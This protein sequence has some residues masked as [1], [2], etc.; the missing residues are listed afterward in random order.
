M[1][2]EDE[3]RDAIL[4]VLANKQDLPG[5]LTAQEV[6]DKLGLTAI[7]QRTWSQYDCDA[8]FCYYS[9]TLKWRFICDAKGLYLPKCVK[10]TQ[11]CNKVSVVVMSLQPK[12]RN[13]H[14]KMQLFVVWRNYVDDTYDCIDLIPTKALSGEGLYEAFGWLADELKKKRGIYTS[15]TDTTT[16][17]RWSSMWTKATG[18]YKKIT[19]RQLITLF[20]LD[21]AQFSLNVQ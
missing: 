9:I 2:A 4:L 1:L 12:I 8:T 5:A 19:V 11:V 16:T 6:T 10:N 21:R 20:R 3:L 13:K 17:S 7:R 18:F 15:P 14:N